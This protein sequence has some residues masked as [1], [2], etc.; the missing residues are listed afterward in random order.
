[1][2]W[3]DTR[4]TKKLYA[5][6]CSIHEYDDIRIDVQQLQS[7]ISMNRELLLQQSRQ[8]YMDPSSIQL[9]LKIITMLRQKTKEKKGKKK[10]NEILF[11]CSYLCCYCKSKC[12][13]S[14]K[15]EK[16]K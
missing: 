3:H 14:V 5:V 16:K 1:M 12:L 10:S 9:P 11:F 8:I 13:I 15:Y 2:A 4:K 7:M 6:Q